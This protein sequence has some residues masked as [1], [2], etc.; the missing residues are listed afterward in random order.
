MLRAGLA[1]PDSSGRRTFRLGVSDGGAY[2]AGRLLNQQGFEFEP[3]VFFGGPHL[4]QAGFGMKK[5]FYLTP[6]TP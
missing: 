5:R 3:F 2:V 1:F 6:G 4:Y